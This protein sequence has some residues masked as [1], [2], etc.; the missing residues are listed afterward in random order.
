[1]PRRAYVSLGILF[2]FISDKPIAYD[3]RFL[4]SDFTNCSLQSYNEVFDLLHQAAKPLADHQ[5][6]FETP[7]DLSHSLVEVPLG[8]SSS[9]SQTTRIFSRVTSP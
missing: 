6:E 9:N 5:K 8:A 3:Q 4:D 2:I 1:M 7:D